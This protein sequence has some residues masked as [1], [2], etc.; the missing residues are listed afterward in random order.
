MTD[1]INGDI[2]FFGFRLVD[3]IKAKST[4]TSV[5]YNQSPVTICV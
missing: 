2:R 1:L 3:L 5:S 4:V